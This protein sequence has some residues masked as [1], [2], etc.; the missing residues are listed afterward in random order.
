MWDDPVASLVSGAL[1]SPKESPEVRVFL[2]EKWEGGGLVRH[3]DGPG[4]TR[5]VFTILSTT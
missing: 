3:T 4:V 1:G 5:T 2:Y